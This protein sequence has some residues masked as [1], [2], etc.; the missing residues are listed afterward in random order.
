MV[1]E[2]ANYLARVR[3]GMARET[4]NSEVAAAPTQKHEFVMKIEGL[5]AGTTASVVGVD[6]QNIPVRVVSPMPSFGG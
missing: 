3:S 1:A 4:S 6:G 5:P 2:T